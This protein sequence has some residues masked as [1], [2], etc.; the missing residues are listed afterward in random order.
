MSRASSVSGRER[1]NA[2]KRGKGNK[3]RRDESDSLD[4]RHLYGPFGP[5][6]SWVSQTPY[7]PVQGSQYSMPLQQ[8]YGGQMQP[9][10]AQSGQPYPAAMQPG[11]AQFSP[12]I[13][14]VGV[15]LLA[16]HGLWN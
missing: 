5:Q 2:A 3:H 15:L 16:S 4:S 9:V 13:P 7:G 11:F 8:A 1:S 10:Y 14:A 6:Q 12:N